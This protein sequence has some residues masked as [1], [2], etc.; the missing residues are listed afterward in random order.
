[1]VIEENNLRKSIMKL[2]LPVV[3]EQ[4][5]IMIVGVISMAYAGHIGKEAI[6]AV[7]FNNSMHMFIIG[8]F[9]AISTGSTVLIARLIGFGDIE[10][11]KMAIRHSVV[12]GGI[13]AFLLSVIF[14]IFSSNI[15]RFLF[16]GAEEAV[17]KATETYFRII[18]YSLPL[19]LLNVIISGGL[20]GAGDTKTP[21]LIANVVNIL[22]AALG[23][24][25]IFGINL[26][27][28]ETKGLGIEGAAVSVAV[29]RAL[30]GILSFLALCK[31]NSI[32]KV[33][34]FQKFKPDKDLVSRMLNIG[35]PASME[36][37][38]MYG[39][40]LIFQMILVRMGTL[41]S[42]VYQVIMS[43]SNIIASPMWGFSIASTTLVG[44]C[45]GA[46]KPDTAEKSIWLT[47][48]IAVLITVVITIILFA[49]PSLFLSIYTKD[50]EVMKTGISSLRLYCMAQP[51]M[52]IVYVLSGA[53]RGAGDIKYV[54][55]T[56]FLGIW[57]GRILLTILLERFLRLGISGVWIAM[58]MDFLVRSVMY[59]S[60]LKRGKWKVKVV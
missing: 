60:R 30:G 42:A 59:V 37:L 57:C 52:V 56:T 26:G 46:K 48:K 8:I 29:S 28:I 25:L 11:A 43:I 27:G 16:N 55:T 15:V 17:L 53:M 31:R 40:F 51:F 47:Q 35:I 54:M 13:L 1:M 14:F 5:M 2:A 58:L 33:N 6:N 3:A 38:L 12:L 50:P 4:F 18:L 19:A 49:F 23:Y 24:I 36:Q 10:K 9:A 20:R 7:G 39:G 41:A 21:M 34:V 44:Q 45:L 22:N 32:I